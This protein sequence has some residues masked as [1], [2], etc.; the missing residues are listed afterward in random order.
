MEGGNGTLRTHDRCYEVGLR[1]V[2]ARTLCALNNSSCCLLRSADRYDGLGQETHRVAAHFPQLHGQVAQVGE[3]L[4][5]ISGKQGTNLQRKPEL[6]AG[7]ATSNQAHCNNLVT[8][9]LE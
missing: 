5:A 2:P 1:G 7:A 6:T 9:D 3:V 4:V 8:P